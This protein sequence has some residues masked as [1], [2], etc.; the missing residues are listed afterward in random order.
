[1]PDVY[2]QHQGNEDW[3]IYDPFEDPQP[4]PYW[5]RC[6]LIPGESV[7]IPGS[8]WHNVF[9]PVDTIGISVDITSAATGENG[10][11]DHDEDNDDDV[12]LVEDP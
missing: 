12:V 6:D 7:F 5:Q 9:S 1:M 11:H 4:P 3:L 8:W 10:L 2:E